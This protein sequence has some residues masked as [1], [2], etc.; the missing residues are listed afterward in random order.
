MSWVDDVLEKLGALASGPSQEEVTATVTLGEVSLEAR[1]HPRFGVF[2]LRTAGSQSWPLDD[3]FAALGADPVDTGN[4]PV[5][6]VSLRGALPTRSVSALLELGEDLSAPLV[7][8]APA[9]TW[10]L[11]P[12]VLERATLEVG[13][14]GG[15]DGAYVAVSG[16]GVLPGADPGEAPV[17]GIEVEGRL[18]ADG[19]W[20]LDVALHLVEDAAQAGVAGLLPR[21]SAMHTAPGAPR[22]PLPTPSPFLEGTTL[23]EVLVELRGEGAERS[24]TASCVGRLGFDLGDPSG[25]RQDPARAP[26]LQLEIQIDSAVR[27]RGSVSL[28]SADPVVLEL[29]L[30]ADREDATVIGIYR[31]GTT[32]RPLD[33]AALAPHELGLPALAVHVEQVVLVWSRTE[34]RSR[35]LVAVEVSA[36]DAV[37][38]DLPIVGKLFP[39]PGLSVG[40]LLMAAVGTFTPAD[41]TA[42]NDVLATP[43]ETVLPD[44]TPVTGA[45]LT[46]LPDEASVP[47]GLRVVARLDV[48]TGQYDLD[49]ADPPPTELATT[50][51]GP[52]APAPAPVPSD[53]TRWR[54]VQRSFGPVHLAR[55]GLAYDADA[56]AIT[57]R[58]DAS[59][60]LAGL[61]LSMT[62]L[63]LRTPL[64]QLA[65]LLELDGIAAS[66]TSGD[67][68]VEG[69]FLR[70]SVTEPAPGAGAE[71]FLGSATVRTPTFTVSVAGGL[72]EVWGE[73]SLFVFAALNRDVGGPAA[74]YVKGLALGFGYNRDFL[75]PAIESVATHQFL[76][77]LEGPDRAPTP[78]ASAAMLDRLS[79]SAP[80]RLGSYWVAAGLRFESFGI[81]RSKAVVLVRLGHEVEILLLG[82]SELTLPRQGPAYVRAELA[83]KVSVRPAAG[84][85]LAEAMLTENSYVFDRDCHL[86]GRFAF[87]LWFGEHPS[88]GD[89]V[90]SL[91][92]Y[93]P[94][95]RRP[96]HYPQVP[97]LGISWTKGAL[98][99]KGEAYFALTPS[100]VMAGGQLEAAYH[101]EGLRASFVL[102]AHFLIAW[103]P[104]FYDIDIAMTVRVSLVTKTFLGPVV[105]DAVLG[106][107]I[108]V[109]GPEFAGRARVHWGILSFDV[110]FGAIATARPTPRDLSWEEFR[111]SFLPAAASICQIQITSGLVREQEGT[112]GETVWVVRGDALR[113]ATRSAIP[114]TAVSVTQALGRTPVPLPPGT[115][116]VVGIQSMGQ[117]TITSEHRVALRSTGTSATAI[118]L[119]LGE[120]LGVVRQSVPR[121][122][123]NDLPVKATPSA[124]VLP[125]RAVGLSG[126]RPRVADPAPVVTYPLTRFDLT[127]IPRDRVSH[128]VPGPAVQ[129]P[130][131]SQLTSATVFE[132]IADTVGEPTDVRREAVV[133]QARSWGF[134]EDDTDVAQSV[135]ASGAAELLAS[136]PALGEETSLGGPA[137]RVTT[138]LA[139]A[140]PAGV[141]LTVPAPVRRRIVELL[142]LVSTRRYVEDG[143]GSAP[144]AAG[145]VLGN[146]GDRHLVLDAEGAT[147]GPAPS[148]ERT[149][150]AG[151]GAV[152]SLGTGEDDLDVDPAAPAAPDARLEIDPTGGDPGVAVRDEAEEPGRLEMR[153]V[154]I[155]RY[156]DLLRDQVRSGGTDLLPDAARV[157]VAAVTAST[158]EAS[159]VSGWHG[160]SLLL[161]VAPRTFLADGGLVRAAVDRS[162]EIG[163]MRGAEMVQ[164]NT[165]SSGASMLTITTLPA[166]TRTVSVV[167]RRQQSTSSMASELDVDLLDEHGTVL[168]R[169]V[170]RHVLR[171]GESDLAL[172]HR[173]PQTAAA[174]G[175]G[176]VTVRVRV[177]GKVWGLHGVLGFDHEP[178]EVRRNWRPV[179][180]ALAAPAQD[181]AARS[182]IRLVP[183][184]AGRGAA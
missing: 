143:G 132:R 153:V 57:V 68:S 27:F 103:K 162:E 155:G 139:P 184:D 169:L 121:Q 141:D 151:G 109:W 171:D 5:T 161:R 6:G 172:L 84:T 50:T 83:L 116:T 175:D 74:F 97:R 67:V 177:H 10:D 148:L 60:E 21:L 14:E 30:S 122:L 66:Y 165:D 56:K 18:Q 100:S 178:A 168:R 16:R 40:C 87:A 167:L 88:S 79:A 63:G 19:G 13:V 117:G 22:P 15:S 160:D 47:A 29:D 77:A 101:D 31:S 95:F 12:V 23:T 149:L 73:V 70:R 33:L 120:G 98:T 25:T 99:V 119:E 64:A 118:D 51:P 28:G 123:W 176:H 107:A 104:F 110:D 62:G 20:E 159:L 71:E 131:G 147:G 157:V 65:P 133:A 138:Q 54:Q 37:D 82:L 130:T 72:S 76:G 166:R 180:T 49:A 146:A 61:R 144:V 134:L 44:G 39:A 80:A 174:P 8:S 55:V 137:T 126:L 91:G 36:A 181:T 24:L 125:H 11:G 164:G 78:E 129:A 7:R 128:L 75:P 35:C 136:A 114:C 42:V 45:P 58:L 152:F 108:R 53:G 69:L 156:G 135:L 34:A 112:S 115:G 154:E 179:A 111:D 9:P 158:P 90:L 93:H 59:V 163:T 81:I 4:L 113:L 150:V 2:T 85:A 183:A 94:R 32:T 1:V 41:L 17:D 127:R 96:A 52:S 48:G 43:R 3:L 86:T 124:D 46:G 145:S 106:A 140:P 170:H 105:L 102:L 92:G 38:P 26:G 89:F 182:T 173:V 142:A